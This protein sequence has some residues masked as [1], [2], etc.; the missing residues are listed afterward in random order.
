MVGCS[1]DLESK[2]LLLVRSCFNQASYDWYEI[3]PPIFMSVRY[4]ENFLIKKHIQTF[5]CL[6]KLSRV[7]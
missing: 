4:P 3:Y 1:T 5:P 2:I 7:V 6:T